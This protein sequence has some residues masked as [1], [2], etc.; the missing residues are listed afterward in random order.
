MQKDQIMVVLM[1][2][3]AVCRDCVSE[4]LEQAEAAVLNILVFVVS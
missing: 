2:R 3:L 1:H 4:I